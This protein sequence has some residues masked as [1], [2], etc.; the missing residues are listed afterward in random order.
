MKSFSTSIRTILILITVSP[1]FMNAQES[2]FEK[3]TAAYNS[4]DFQEAIAQY[5]NILNEKQH[6]AAVY[7]NLGNAHYKLGQIAPSIYYY[8][9]ALLLNP[10]DP[11]I[12]NNLGFAQNM[13]L[14]AIQPLPQTDLHRFY[15]RL[16]YQMSMDTW[17]ITGVCFMIIFVIGFLFFRAMDNPNPKRIAFIGSLLGLLLSLYCTAMAYLQYSAYRSDRPAIV[18]DEE[19]IVRSE[20]NNSA[21]EAFRLHEGTKVQLR[22]ELNPWVKVSLADGQ[23]GW[24]PISAIQVLKDF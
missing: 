17:A 11:E 3:A 21:P 14:D 12:L 16:V 6:S 23:T 18:F 22:D 24:L 13:T 8:E 1:A 20:P 4:G 2:H 9:K 15:N 19:V 5:K 10:N 7:Y